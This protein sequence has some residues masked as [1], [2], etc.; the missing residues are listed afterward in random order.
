MVRS[1]V[2][3]DRPKPEQA[4][5]RTV[6]TSARNAGVIP[7]PEN[8]NS[9]DDGLGAKPKKKRRTQAQKL[10]E[11]ASQ[12]ELFHGQDGTS[13]ATVGI[14]GHRETH[15]LQSRGFH[16]WLKHQFYVAER[17]APNQNAFTAA[18]GCLDAQAQ[19]DGPEIPVFVRVASWDECIFLDL[20]DPSW[21]AVEVST[22]GWK[23]VDR[24]AVKFRRPPGL[25]PLPVPIA[26][27]DIRELRSLINL[28]SERDW[29]L[30]VAWMLAALNPNIPCPILIVQGEQGSAKSTLCRIVRGLIDPSV[31][32]LRTTSRHERDLMIAATNSWVLMFD[33][34]S[35]MRPW[36]SDALSRLATGGGFSVRELYTN[37]DEVLFDA[38][39]P[40][41]INGIEDLARRD[42]LRDRSVVLEL[43]PIPHSSRRTE[44]EVL[45]KLDTIQPR[46][47]GAL[48]DAIHVALVNAP[49][50]SL[51][52]LPR[53][54]DSV[55]WATGAE[56]ALS[57][58]EGT[59]LRD[60][61]ENK[62]D[63]TM[64]GVEL[65][66]VQK[67]IRDLVDRRIR[68]EGTWTELQDRLD[69]Q[70]PETQQ[71]SKEWPKTP[72]WLSR[73]VRRAAGSLR[74]VGIDISFGQRTGL[75]STKF[76]VISRTDSGGDAGDADD[77]WA[78]S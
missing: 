43:P 70:V 1:S 33:N 57:W 64:A 59:V 44:A 24:P 52:S 54:A 72:N 56:A 71:R 21:G 60:H 49:D 27:G 14:D 13:Y 37:A 53:M 28:E 47:L 38:R 51:P 4:L 35:G 12:S 42:D 76:V 31:A 8:P 9:P 46:A 10:I 6:H 36:F 20:G 67:A 75:G 7:P 34:L 66:L 23:L 73:R 65:D 77:P 78:L 69:E 17:N 26:G 2:P 32:G 15:P 30:L 41:V 50:V 48:L 39:R 40:I 61:L 45:Q 58:P 22:R 11:M 19:F 68:W 55:C 16:R 63:A 3:D 74:D 29:R 5:A 25:A 62:K 18:I